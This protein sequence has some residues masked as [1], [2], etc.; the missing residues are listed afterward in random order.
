MLLH[1]IIINHS[2]KNPGNE[3]TRNTN[4]EGTEF[5]KNNDGSTLRIS[6]GRRP[7]NEKLINRKRTPTETIHIN[8]KKKR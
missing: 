1:H 4:N 7:V 6:R 3:E 5:V 8:V 2:N